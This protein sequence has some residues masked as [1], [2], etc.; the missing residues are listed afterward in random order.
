[1]SVADWSAA[2]EAEAQRRH[3]ERRRGFTTR[4][5]VQIIERD[6]RSEIWGTATDDEIAEY[7]NVSPRAVRWLRRRLVRDLCLAELLRDLEQLADLVAWK[8]SRA[9]LLREVVRRAIERA[10]AARNARRAA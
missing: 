10:T 9:D 2:D 1:M 5:L 8:G 7:R 6:L 4:R 3:D